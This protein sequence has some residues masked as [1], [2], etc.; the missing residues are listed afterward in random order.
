MIVL[1]KPSDQS[2]Y[3]NLIDIIDEMEISKIRYYM[4]KLTTADK[5]LMRDFKRTHVGN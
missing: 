4:E 5:G 3:Q 2:C 1:V